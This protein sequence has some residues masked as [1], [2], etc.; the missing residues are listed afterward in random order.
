MYPYLCILTLALMTIGQF[1]TLGESS[2]VFVEFAL[3]HPC[4]VFGDLDVWFNSRH[5]HLPDGKRYITLEAYDPSR[6]PFHRAMYLIETIDGVTHIHGQGNFPSLR[7][8]VESLVLTTKGNEF[9][10]ILEITKRKVDGYDSEIV[11]FGI[12]EI[13]QG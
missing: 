4:H 13:N 10:L 11:E 2:P 1:I 8:P 9:D 12:E 5:K 7:K 6:K 3:K